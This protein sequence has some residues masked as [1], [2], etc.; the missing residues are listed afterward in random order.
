MCCLLGSVCVCVSMYSVSWL[1][2]LSYEQYLQEIVS[3]K[4]SRT[5]NAYDFFGLLLFVCLIVFSFC[6][7]ALFHM[8]TPI[9]AESA[10]KHQ[11]THRCKKLRFYSGH[12]FLRFLT[13]F[14]LPT[15]FIFK[16]FHWKYH[17]KS[18]SKQR[19]Q[20][21][22]GSFPSTYTSRHAL[23]SSSSSSSP[24]SKNWFRWHNVNH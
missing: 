5:K 4:P 20:I 2:R 11:S 12:V 1:F 23:E 17:L 3:T 14:I 6:P 19:K 22:T 13:F 21:I 15:F 7:L 24:S 8:G 18:L 9:C 16:N 10:V